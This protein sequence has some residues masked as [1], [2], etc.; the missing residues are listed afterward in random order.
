M[1]TKSPQSAYK[2]C[3]IRRPG[4]PAIAGKKSR[5]VFGISGSTYLPN[6]DKNNS[7]NN[8]PNIKN[9]NNDDLESLSDGD[10]MYAS[11]FLWA[12]NSSSLSMSVQPE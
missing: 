1:S 12:Q 2:L 3:W 11:L 9:D 7:S 4:Q 8:N 10:Q 6:P 5:L